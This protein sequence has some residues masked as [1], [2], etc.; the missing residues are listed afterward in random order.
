MKPKVGFVF[1]TLFLLVASTACV[2]AASV[3]PAPTQTSMSSVPFPVDTGSGSIAELLNGTATASA[4]LGT[5]GA[6]ATPTG[7]YIVYTTIPEATATP[8]RI[9]VP[10]ATPGHPSSYTVAPGDTLFCI[11]RRYN[12]DP[13][14]LMTVNNLNETTG[15]QLTVGQTLNLPQDS[16]WP[17][18]YG[19]RGLL[20]HPT[21]VTVMPGDSLNG[22]ACNF[23]DVDPN[24]ILMANGLQSADQIQ[25]GQVLHI[26]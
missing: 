10:T 26:P 3:A 12:L 22:I 17:G 19:Q 18:T 21:D 7:P 16:T 8:T 23:G 1:A 4:L 20:E 25:V 9:P 13:E 5:P 6:A 14:Q 11:A 15:A 2:R 24:A